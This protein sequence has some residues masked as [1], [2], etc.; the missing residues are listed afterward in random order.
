MEVYVVG[1]HLN[2]LYIY[3]NREV[4]GWVFKDSEFLLDSALIGI[5]VVNTLNMIC[6]NNVLWNTIGITWL[7][8]N[9]TIDLTAKSPSNQLMLIVYILQKHAYKPVTQVDLFHYRRI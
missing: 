3:F 5:Y 7:L 2:L 9:C 6:K 4:Q 8:T 1:A